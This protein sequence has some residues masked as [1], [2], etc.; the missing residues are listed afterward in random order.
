MKFDFYF[1]L[2]EK[3]TF[4][5]SLLPKPVIFS[6]WML[7]SFKV[8]STK[9][10]RKDVESTS[11]GTRALNQKSKTENKTFFLTNTAINKGEREFDYK[12]AVDFVFTQS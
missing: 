2:S 5:A 9:R 10:F 6:N 7:A 1:F 8:S 4:S 11:K 12:R 3:R